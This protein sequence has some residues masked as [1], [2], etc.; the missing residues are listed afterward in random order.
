MKGGACRA[1]AARDAPSLRLPDY[2]TVG[3]QAY[4]KSVDGMRDTQRMLSCT[5]IDHPGKSTGGRTPWHFRQ[6]PCRPS[7]E[8]PWTA[9]I[10]PIPQFPLDIQFM[11]GEARS[12]D[13]REASQNKGRRQTITP[14]RSAPR[15]GSGTLSSSHRSRRAR[16]RL[17]VGSGPPFAAGASRVRAFFL[18]QDGP[19]VE[20]QIA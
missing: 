12:Q 3:G 5:S 20:E 18:L 13:P 1:R 11:T 8:T 17:I 16:V 10:G 14:T 9:P 2:P 7:T 15:L 6:A 4:Q 19:P